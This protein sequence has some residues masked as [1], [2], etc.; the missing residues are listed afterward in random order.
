MKRLAP[1]PALCA[2]CAVLALCALSLAGAAVRTPIAAAADGPLRVDGRHFVDPKGRI[3]ILHGIFVVW[4]SDPLYP[5]DDPTSPNQ[6]LSADAANIREAGFDLVRLAWYW[7]GL[8]PTQ[9]AYSQTYLDG[10][11][12]VEEK[13]ADDG[14]YTLLDSHQ[15]QFNRT[16]GDKPGFPQWATVIDDLAPNPLPFPLGYFQ[17]ATGRAFANLYANREVAGEGIAD[18]YGDAW[19]RVAARFAARPMVLGYDLINEP[20]PG[21]QSGWDQTCGDDAGCADYDRTVSQPFQTSLARSI[22]DADRDHPVFYEPSFFFNSGHPNHF[23]RAPAD[24]RP[25]AFS[26]HGQCSTHGIYQ[27]TGDPSWIEKG[28]EVC[29]PEEI[30]TMHNAVEAAGRIGGPPLMTEVTGTGSEDDVELNCL[31]ERAD[32]FQTGFTFGLGPGRLRSAN[33]ERPGAPF[34]RQVLSRVY[35]RAIAGDRA[36]FGFDVR[37][38]IFR[39]RY[40]PTPSS[41][42]PTVVTVPPAQYSGAYETI[43]KGAEVTS[44]PGAERLR[45]VADRDS[46]RVVI[47]ISPEPGDS[48]ARP[49]FPQCQMDDDGALS[50]NAPTTKITRVSPHSLRKAVAGGLAV[51]ADCVRSCRLHARVVIGVR[52]ARRLGLAG[53]G[54]SDPLTIGGGRGAADSPGPLR[55]TVDL[56][57]RARRALIDRKSAT[58]RLTVETRVPGRAGR[59]TVSRTIRL[60]G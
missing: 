41:R 5:L 33:L 19:R 58:I 22:R 44:E 47:R 21:V 20:F 49:D 28:H 57:N 17:P 24:V 54:R 40:R 46:R 56:S 4:K 7:E 27:A 39:L 45:V 38:G 60:Q 31:L 48:T 55:F 26:F 53:P 32:Y 13:L 59:E 11:A 42:G 15:D 52:L 16:F 6:F 8:E 35:P 51:E 10:I 12:A 50:P 34:Q 29:P 23:R 18:A 25:A 30:R 3:V 1:L 36:H 37:T 9:G 43:V 2:R 14:V